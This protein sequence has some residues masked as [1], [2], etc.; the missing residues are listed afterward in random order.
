MPKTNE[1]Q[2]FQKIKKTINILSLGKAERRNLPPD[3]LALINAPALLGKR[4]AL[5]EKAVNLISSDLFALPV[6][7]RS[8]KYESAF[9]SLLSGI[10]TNSQ[11]FFYDDLKNKEEHIEHPLDHYMLLL[12][13]TVQAALTL[14]N[15]QIIFKL[16]REKIKTI[17][18]KNGLEELKKEDDIFAESEK[19]IC[20][21]I[22]TLVSKAQTAIKAHQNDLK[23]SMS[24]ED[25]SRYKKAYSQYLNN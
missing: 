10:E 19:K 25:E 5:Y 17:L 9:V 23:K 7:E 11:I 1:T 8:A 6:S 13:D 20:E 14:C 2:I 15:H 24:K 4:D 18:G 16:D 12:A 21:C 22:A 3:S